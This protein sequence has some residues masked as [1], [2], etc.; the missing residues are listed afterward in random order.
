MA[1]VETLIERATDMLF[2]CWHTH[3]TW[4]QSN[5][6]KGVDPYVVCLDCGKEFPFT[7][8]QEQVQ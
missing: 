2:G 3:Y 8:F 5:A 1:K 4:P 7:K 6:A